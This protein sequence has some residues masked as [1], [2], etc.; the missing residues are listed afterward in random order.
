MSLTLLQ[1]GLLALSAF[2]V[3]VW[4]KTRRSPAASVGP[5]AA[6][7]DA[8][9]LSDLDASLLQSVNK[10]TADRLWAY[11]YGAATK[12]RSTQRMDELVR[13]NVI[14]VLQVDALANNYFPR[15]PTLMSE[16]LRALDDPGTASGKLS[17]MIAHD[18][19]LTADILRLANSSLYRVSAHPIETVQRAVA[20]C[21]VD[22]LRGML[23]AA[24][25]RPVFK[26]TSKNFPRVPRALW[27]RTE[28]AAR[29]AELYALATH[30][31]RRF[32]SQMAVLVNALGPLVVYS[33][34]VDVYSR[35]TLFHPNAALCVAL[36]SELA[37]QL[38]CRVAHDWQM[39]PSL[40]EVLEGSGDK[41]LTNALHMGELLGTLAFLE[42]QT[43]VSR[44][45]RSGVLLSAGA[46]ENFADSLWESLAVRRTT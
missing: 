27:T 21:G 6:A 31:D 13:N 22:A 37:P 28:R 17:R 12:S 34:V 4:R 32:E 36:T 25:M 11:C 1:V 9:R 16:L 10:A 38:A 3:T 26:A 23:A 2:G 43:V 29:A 7:S 14:A 35:N 24:M 45:E 5:V 20:V 18:P 44:K 40:I 46:P 33:A 30:P 19:V 39:S 41:S 8:P 15:R 42:S